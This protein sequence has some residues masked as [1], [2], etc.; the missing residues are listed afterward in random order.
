MSAAAVLE[1]LVSAFHARS[2]MDRR[3]E[4]DLHRVGAAGMA[5]RR[6]PLAMAVYELR[7]RQPL[8]LARVVE[9]AVALTNQVEKQ[10]KLQRWRL[11][12]HHD[13]QRVVAV[14]LRWWLADVCP[15]CEGRR[16]EVVSGT[17]MLSDRHCH[18]CGGTGKPSLSAALNDHMLLR[19]R[20]TLRLPAE[21]LS[22]RLDVLEAAAGDEYVRRLGRMFVGAPDGQRAAT[23]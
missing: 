18:A 12:R 4:C 8:D 2:L 19:D 23:P 11:R 16:F 14:V 7:Y 6:Q 13:A 10:A 5:A 21:W 3:Q 22:S 20:E 15:A 9:V 17:P 1:K